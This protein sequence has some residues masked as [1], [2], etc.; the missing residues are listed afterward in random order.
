MY[1][2]PRMIPHTSQATFP[3]RVS[4]FQSTYGDRATG[5]GRRAHPGGANLSLG[6]LTSFPRVWKMGGEQTMLQIPT[7]IKREW[8]SLIAS[9]EKKVEY[10]EDTPY[11]RRRLEGIEAPFSLRLINGMRPDSPR[12][13]VTVV[14]VR[15][16][17]GCYELH[18][19][20]VREV[21]Y[22]DRKKNQPV[23]SRKR[24]PRKR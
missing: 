10:R 12:L 14:R 13:T 3:L 21:S 19:G 11:W 1:G 8:F 23:P 17:K 24:T 16:R 22:W 7:T 4:P 5:D 15:K 6:L 18:L 9:R 20:R 2:S